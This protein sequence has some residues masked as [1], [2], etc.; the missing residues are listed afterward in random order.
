[1]DQ[2]LRTT[3]E[4]VEWMERR[5]IENVSDNE[6]RLEN[7]TSRNNVQIDYDGINLNSIKLGHSLLIVSWIP[8]F[9]SS[10]TSNMD[11]YFDW[12][13][14]SDERRIRFAKMKLVVKLGNTGHMSRSW[15]NSEIKSLFKL[16]K[17][18]RW[19]S[20]RS[21]CLCHT[22]NAYLTNDSVWLKT[23]GQCQR[24]WRSLINFWW[25]VV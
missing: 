21:T 9:F 1:M 16:G 18:W 10:W 8:K 25:D 23:I 19:S 14:I 20:K 6:S 2:K 15:W 22:N 3:R 24:T 7:C 5:T 17:R 12:Y 4:R 13:D 11:H